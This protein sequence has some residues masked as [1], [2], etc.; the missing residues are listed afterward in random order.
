M[1][2]PSLITFSIKRVDIDNPP[3]EDNPALGTVTINGEETTSKEVMEESV[4]QPI[5]KVFLF[6]PLSYCWL[7]I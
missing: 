3:Y 1:P 5:K 6:K 4:N 7:Q 2:D